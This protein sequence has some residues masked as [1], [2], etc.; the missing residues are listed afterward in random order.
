MEHYMSVV[1]PH[2]QLGLEIAMMEK[3]EADIQYYKTALA[4]IEFEMKENVHAALDQAKRDI[5][6]KCEERTSELLALAAAD[7]L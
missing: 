4:R 1:V 2:N 7:A 6:K 5:M 3:K